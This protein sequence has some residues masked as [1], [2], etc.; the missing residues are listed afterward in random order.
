MP[1]PP[2]VIFKDTCCHAVSSLTFSPKTDPGIYD[3]FHNIGCYAPC[4]IVQR[5]DI[6]A[7]QRIALC[8]SFKEPTLAQ[9]SLT[10]VAITEH[11]EGMCWS[12]PTGTYTKY[13]HSWWCNSLTGVWRN[14][15]LTLV[16]TDIPFDNNSNQT[17]RQP[18]N[19]QFDHWNMHNGKAI[20]IGQ[21]V[22]VTILFLDTVDNR[23]K[24]IDKANRVGPSGSPG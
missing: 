5:R 17:S 23:M 1:K 19:L 21:D 18:V 16:I 2:N 22:R 20:R 9:R 10:D 6:T 3:S 13:I 15:N 8:G 12:H 24:L 7:K 14:P 11:L 4:Q